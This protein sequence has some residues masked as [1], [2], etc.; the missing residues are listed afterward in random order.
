MMMKFA[1][2]WHKSIVMIMA[3]GVFIT[4]C[5]SSPKE[6][7]IEREKYLISSG[8][9]KMLADTEEKVD[10][11]KKM[12]QREIFNK[13]KDGTLYYVWADQKACNCLYYGD[14]KAYEIYQQILLTL[15]LRSDDAASAALERAG[16]GGNWGMWGSWRGPFRY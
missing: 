16:P 9:K 8:F 3:L 14:E 4:G 2:K 7:A 13:E 6:K 12:P 5:A 10:H 11:L 1:I 15:K